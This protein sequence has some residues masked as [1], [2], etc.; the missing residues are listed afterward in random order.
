MLPV[1]HFS[2]RLTSAAGP[3]AVIGGIALVVLL[4]P[5]LKLLGGSAG[6]IGPSVPLLFL[7]PVLI[8]STLGGR[9][10]GA[11][12][13]VVA[14][15]AWDWFF[16]PPFYTVTVNYPRD[17]LALVIFVAIA[18]LT[19]QLADSARQR[20]QDALRR[21]AVA[22]ALY[23]LTSA[24]IGSH[25]VPAILSSLTASLYS[26]FRLR[27]CAVLLQ[28]D[29]DWTT[30]AVSGNLPSEL[31]V[32]KNR[33]ASSVAAW[34]AAHKQ[35]SGLPSARARFLPLQA[36]DRTVGVLEIVFRSD[37]G[38]DDERERLISTFAN[39][40]A[41]VIEQARLAEEERSAAIARESDELKTALLSSVSHD[42]RTPLAGIKAAASS[43]LQKDIQWSEEDRLAFTSDIDREAD[44]L[45]RL[46]SDLLDLSRI[47]AGAL[48]PAKQ[49]EDV[50]EMIVRTL[51]RLR[52]QLAGREVATYI[53]PNLPLVP[54]DVVQIEQVLVNLLENAGKYS[55][56]GTPMAVSVEAA[57]SEE[58]HEVRI[59]V[60]DR[61]L[62]I[63]ERDRSQVFDAFHRL[64][65]N[66]D[67]ET[68]TGMGLAI[69][70][71]L[72]EAHGGRVWIEDTPEGGSRFVFSLPIRDTAVQATN[73]LEQSV[74]L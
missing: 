41:L 59:S 58:K 46:V 31:T 37:S 52:P 34:V 64:P 14:V 15:A 55:P 10:A 17:V 53:E 73:A 24:L 68:G 30:T 60:S 2:Q 27:A 54:V 11:L 45:T 49:P 65:S 7:A 5:V 63:R 20:A 19:G 50:E 40:A 35:A 70:K 28:S 51:D 1:N 56:A 39:S 38:L 48:K 25:D 42:L 32:E 18:L 33:S 21:A 16:I 8:T 13:A 69:V 4:V 23:D 74:G 26:V 9:V 67:G 71:G 36:K 72:V 47:E 61:G 57:G 12:V 62:G 6:T 22:Q 44:R 3:L 29:R 66:H 43:L